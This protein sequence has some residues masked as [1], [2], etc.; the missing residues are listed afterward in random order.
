MTVRKGPKRSRRRMRHFFSI[1]LPIS[2]HRQWLTD[3]CT[4]CC[5]SSNRT[6]QRT[7]RFLK[8]V[9]ECAGETKLQVASRRWA[10]FVTEVARAIVVIATGSLQRELSRN[11]GRSVCLQKATHSQV[12]SPLWCLHQRFKLQSGALTQVEMSKFMSLRSDHD[13]ELYSDSFGPVFGQIPERTCCWRRW[14]LR[15]NT[16]H[17]RSCSTIKP[18][19]D[20]PGTSSSNLCA[21]AT[22]AGAARAR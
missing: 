14:K 18:V 15:R 8:F 16:C 21:A 3:V 4:A 1:A 11:A 17:T 12:K 19:P 5:S 22:R 10:P 13:L 2:G 7:L 6:R 20:S 9:E